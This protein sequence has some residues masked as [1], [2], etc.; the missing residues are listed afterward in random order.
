V[1]FD[2]LA[3]ETSH[4]S[5]AV[6]SGR[7]Q[8]FTCSEVSWVCVPTTGSCCTRSP[9]YWSR[10]SSAPAGWRIRHH[11]QSRRHAPPRRGR[12]SKRCSFIP[13]VADE[14]CPHLHG[15]GHRAD[16]VLHLRFRHK[17][18]QAERSTRSLTISTAPRHHRSS[19][20]GTSGP[21][22]FDFRAVEHL[23]L[24]ATRLHR[25]SPSLRVRTAPTR[26]WS[27]RHYP[28]AAGAAPRR[29]ADS[30]SVYAVTRRD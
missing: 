20:A 22:H 21:Q 26:A 12:R 28:R 11:P 3:A 9:R 14:L 27:G 6:V 24:A 13:G 23:K 16:V 19:D 8:G 15:E 2:N 4:G 25:P 18:Q 30:G 7:S 1:L 10:M 5:A 29:E 17:E